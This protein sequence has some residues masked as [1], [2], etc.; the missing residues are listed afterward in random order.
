M[1]Q[2]TVSACATPDAKMLVTARAH[3]E[4]PIDARQRD[5][6]LSLE[7]HTCG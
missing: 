6:N 1:M 4:V 7:R 2:A 5:D 3:Q